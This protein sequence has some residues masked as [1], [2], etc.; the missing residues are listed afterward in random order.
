VLVTLS[1]LCCSL[2]KP[3]PD[4]RHNKVQVA[5]RRGSGHGVLVRAG[6]RINQGTGGRKGGMGGRTPVVEASL[7]LPQVSSPQPLHTGLLLVLLLLPL[8]QPA[9]LAPRA[10]PASEP[11]AAAWGSAR[12]ESMGAC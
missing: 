8:L 6:H 3:V 7:L 9:G 12:Q 2:D 4:E 10:A 1:F 11:S 5:R